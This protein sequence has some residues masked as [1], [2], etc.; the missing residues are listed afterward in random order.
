MVIV[1]VT[2]SDINRNLSGNW[3]GNGNLTGSAVLSYKGCTEEEKVKGNKDEVSKFIRIK[4]LLFVSF[5]CRICQCFCSST[6]PFSL[7]TNNFEI[8]QEVKGTET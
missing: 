7:S 5:S 2:V 1:M 3:Y 6:I 8:K 4:I